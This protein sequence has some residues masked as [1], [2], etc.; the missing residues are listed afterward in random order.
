MKGFG[1]PLFSAMFDQLNCTACSPNG[2]RHLRDEPWGTNERKSS[3]LLCTV[4]FDLYYKTER[5][6]VSFTVCMPHLVKRSILIGDSLLK[7]GPVS[8]VLK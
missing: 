8:E 7:G 2:G 6:H 1:Q 4:L 3:N 5:K